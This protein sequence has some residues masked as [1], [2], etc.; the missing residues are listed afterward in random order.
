MHKGGGNEVGQVL[1]QFLRIF[2]VAEIGGLAGIQCG[3][4][5]SQ[6]FFSFFLPVL[7][8]SQAHG[9]ILLSGQRENEQ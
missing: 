6:R 2:S 9:S 3:K 8:G 1:R 5:W 7:F 4:Q